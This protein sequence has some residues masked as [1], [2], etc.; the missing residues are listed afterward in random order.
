M[1]L[2]EAEVIVRSK[3]DVPIS[4]L[5]QQVVEEAWQSGLYEVMELLEKISPSEIA[6]WALRS[7]DGVLV[8]LLD[9]YGK[10][11]GVKID[12]V[13]LGSMASR[14]LG[15]PTRELL[16]KVSSFSEDRG[17]PFFDFLVEARA[18]A[19]L[20]SQIQKNATKQGL[21]EP[22]AAAYINVHSHAEVRVLAESESKFEVRFGP[23][24]SRIV[25]GLKF[26]TKG[27]SKSKKKDDTISKSADLLACVFENSK[28]TTYL[29]S[30]KYARVGG[31][32]QM[33]QRT[34]AVKFLAYAS[35]SASDGSDFPELL[36]FVNEQFGKTI[37]A[38]DFQWQPGLVLD[39]RF[40]DGAKVFIESNDSYPQ[41]KTNAF[42]IGT[43]DE[44]VDHLDNQA[45]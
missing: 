42:F 16:E 19:N 29:L 17:L 15:V 1:K 27:K 28:C 38:A 32:H 39:G 18:S 44:F 7:E 22:I 34:D 10:S 24:G 13:K 45:P 5:M 14:K 2:N 43:S 6:L 3:T 12:S 31:G 4:E 35:I 25:E 40:F 30:H 26:K 37:T 8:E 9:S 23:D 11:T 36:A 41:L 20:S 21:Y 33:N